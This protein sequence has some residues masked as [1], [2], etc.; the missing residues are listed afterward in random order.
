MGRSN[1]YI[2][3]HRTNSALFFFNHAIARIG[4]PHSIVIDHGKHFRNHMMFELTAK[5]GLSHDNS[6]PYYPQSNG[7]IEAIKKILKH[8]LKRMIG[9]RKINWHLILYSTLWA[10]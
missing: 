9:V 3:K 8:M 7:K 4:V 5:L 10:Y 2:Q 6:T 1:V